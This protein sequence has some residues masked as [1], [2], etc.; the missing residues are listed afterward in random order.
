M[1][2]L[3]AAVLG[4]VAAFGLFELYAWYRVSKDPATPDRE[5]DP[6]R[7]GEAV[8]IEDFALLAG[9]HI[10][11][12]RVELKG[13]IWKA[14]NHTPGVRPAVGDR[15]RIVERRSLTLIVEQIPR[16]SEHLIGE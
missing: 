2:Y 3:I 1:E 10:H 6:T 8:V 5:I 13:A 11:G 12:G 9:Q 14:E 7:D 4:A 16:T 15:V